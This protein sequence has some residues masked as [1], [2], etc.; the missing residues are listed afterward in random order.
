MYFWA[1]LHDTVT[2][3]LLITSL[4]EAFPCCGE[5]V[6]CISRGCFYVVCS[7][8]APWLNAVSC[9]CA[10]KKVKRVEYLSWVKS[11][12]FDIESSI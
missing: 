9:F 1:L 11:V 12:I 4:F 3:L 7:Q 6:L 8:W 10:P 2:P 5:V